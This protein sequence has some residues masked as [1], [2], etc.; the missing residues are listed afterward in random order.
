MKQKQPKDI[1]MFWNMS[2]ILNILRQYWNQA[3]NV[4]PMKWDLKNYKPVFLNVFNTSNFRH[5]TKVRK[6]MYIFNFIFLSRMILFQN[7]LIVGMI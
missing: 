2:N 4:S 6:A 5:L 3:R 1:E 7:T